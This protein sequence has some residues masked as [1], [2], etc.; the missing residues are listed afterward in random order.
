MAD[1]KKAENAAVELLK[2]YT[3]EEPLVPVFEIAQNEGLTIKMFNPDDQLRNVAG[4]LDIKEKTIYVNSQEPANRQ[5]FTIAHELGH[6]I[7]E[8]EENKIGVLLRY[9]EIRNKNKDPLEQEANCFAAELLV[10]RDM[11]KKVKSEYNLSQKDDIDILARLFGVSKE[12]MG[13]RLKHA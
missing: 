2:K 11:L 1:Y 7:L 10:P 9:P 5:T 13:Y 12:V 4:F 8:H 3:I 6:Y